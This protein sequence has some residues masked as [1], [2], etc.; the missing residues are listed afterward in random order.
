MYI[1]P[2]TKIY[3]TFSE[4][5]EEQDRYGG[6][7]FDEEQRLSISDLA[8]GK[9]NI[10]IGEP[11]IGKTLLLT[12]I[13]DHLD[14]EGIANT[15]ISLRQ[16][17]S[18][19]AI[20]KFAET[21]TNAPKV[22]LLDSLDEVQS[23]SLPSVLPKLEE[24]SKKHPHLSIYLSARWVFISKHSKSFP[25]YRFIMILP[26]SRRQVREYLS[27]AGRSQGEIDML[28]NRIMSFNHRT[29]VIQIPRYLFY[30]VHFMKSKGVEAAVDVSRNELFE[31]FIY[32]KLELEE[33][34]LN[35]DTRSLMK[36]LL[37]KLALTMEIYQTNT[38][39]KDELMTFFDDLKSDLKVALL[40]QITLQAFFDNSLLKDNLDYVEFENTE[41]Q[42]YLAAKEITRF[43]DPSWTAFNFAA[44]PNANDTTPHGS[45]P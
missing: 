44:D 12:K 26:F 3:S 32:S 21:V 35:A 27:A 43:P 23:S 11:G 2:I 5:K 7:L 19:D 45:M 16:T 6:V 36:R 24:I 17:D 15:L 22:L 14:N 34:K 31:Y 40:S 4:A 9:R 20:H 13:K 30:L 39:S 28:L 1:T 42:E 29:L 18:A 25:E 33:Q 37:E 38:I 10:V 8:Q 41:F